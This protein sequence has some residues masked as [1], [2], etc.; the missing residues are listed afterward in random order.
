M[1]FWAPWRMA[2]RSGP[3]DVSTHMRSSTWQVVD[4]LIWRGIWWRGT[5][6]C[7][8]GESALLI[9]TCNLGFYDC[10]AHHRIPRHEARGACH[11]RPSRND[12]EIHA[13]SWRCYTLPSDDDFLKLKILHCLFLYIVTID[14]DNYLFVCF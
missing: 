5:W 2:G 8:N 1:F 4:P 11:T 12:R 10:E 7:G 13:L 3:T 14:F 9:G 6:A